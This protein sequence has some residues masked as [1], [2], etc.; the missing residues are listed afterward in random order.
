MASPLNKSY[1]E[2]AKTD[3]WTILVS[4]SVSTVMRWSKRRP[5]C[6]KERDEAT[7]QLQ[8]GDCLVFIDKDMRKPEYIMF[9]DDSGVWN[10]KNDKI[11]LINFLD[12]EPEVMA[13]IIS[14][15]PDMM[16]VIKRQRNERAKRHQELYWSYEYKNRKKS[17]D[18]FMVAQY[19]DCFLYGSSSP[20]KPDPPAALF[21]SYHTA[22]TPSEIIW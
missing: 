14:V 11:K 13:V 8:Y 12:R 17:F 2:L 19:M 7:S 1:V 16:D 20:I 22:P 5:W 4:D 18:D 3:K 15:Y 9:T 10:K 21:G 6:T